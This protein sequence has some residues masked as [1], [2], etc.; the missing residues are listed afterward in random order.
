MLDSRFKSYYGFSQS[1]VRSILADVVLL[2][3]TKLSALASQHGGYNTTTGGVENWYR[4]S[5]VLEWLMING[6]GSS[7]NDTNDIQKSNNLDTNSKFIDYLLSR[8]RFQLKIQDV[9]MKEEIF[10]TTYLK[11]FTYQNLENNEDTAFAF[12]LYSGYL[13][14]DASN[15]NKSALKIPNEEMEERLI[16]SVNRWRR[17]RFPYYETDQVVQEGMLSV[18]DGKFDRF[19]D[20]L[21]KFSDN[22]NLTVDIADELDYGRTIFVLCLALAGNYSVR[23]R[24]EFSTDIILAAKRN[25]LDDHDASRQKIA[26][27]FQIATI[28]NE[29]ED[30]DK[31]VAVANEK[32]KM[33]LKTIDM[34]YY[35]SSFFNTIDYG[36]IEKVV[37][38]GLVFSRNN[39]TLA[40]NVVRM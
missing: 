18:I 36:H 30:A 19:R 2:P 22:A 9:L 29:E 13:I 1:E 14:T 6:N 5:S 7:S 38:V 4:T 32:A 25:Q 39:L 34:Q 11:H 20:F 10:V 23:A 33:M 15:N 8:D 17:K 12:L 35:K 40:G 31:N 37:L 16:D 21:K 26:V 27:I 28:I 24:L 3:E